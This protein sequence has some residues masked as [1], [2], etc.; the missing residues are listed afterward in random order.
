[1]I[2]AISDAGTR[3]DTVQAAH[4]L[5]QAISVS[6]SMASLLSVDA[7]RSTVPS[8]D[9]VAPS[10]LSE[11]MRL[12]REAR[13]ADRDVVL[14]LPAEALRDPRLRRLL[15]LSVVTV[16]P[17]ADD[18]RAAV[19]LGDAGAAADDALPMWHLGCRRSG[20]GPAAT[21]FA[22]RMTELG[23]PHRLLPVTLPALSRA[24]AADLA[25][26][27]TGPRVLDAGL[28]LLS[29]LR[30]VVADP[31][32][33]RIDT[34]ALDARSEA[35]RVAMTADARSFVERLRDLADDLER[36]DRDHGPTAQDLAH[37][38]VLD[39]WAPEILPVRILRGLAI[40]HPSIRNGRPVRTTQVMATD[41]ATWAR[42]LSR[43]YVLKS[44]VGAARPA[45]L[46]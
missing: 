19:A 23:H 11:T 13:E 8:F 29:A 39:D 4:L 45:R 22:A 43:Y 17:Y 44:P 6:G 28:L 21:A 32:A 33:E 25:R 41:N 12:V 7:E 42:T 35:E 3:A 16:G 34:P 2:I 36:L 5:V 38:P 20:G 31:S 1:L 40:D 26:G 37:A 10:T 15:D 18:E 27:V 30:K 14:A 24:E 46:Q 9:G